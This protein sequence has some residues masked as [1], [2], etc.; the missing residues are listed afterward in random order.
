[1]SILKLFEAFQPFL[2][3]IA[4][5]A[6]S[7]YL[8]PKITKRWQDQQK[9]IELKTNFISEISESVLKMILAV[10]FAEVHS[11][12]QT[13][14]QYSAAYREWE[15]EKAI[16]G[17]K[18]R[19]YFPNT[20]L[21]QDWDEYADIVTE[22]YALSGTTDTAFRNDRL[23]G[24]N[25]YFDNAAIDWESL[26]KHHLKEGGFNKFQIYSKAWFSLR[27]STLD[28]KDALVQ[29]ILNS[30]VALFNY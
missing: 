1:M 12:S 5:G 27:K 8:I 7:H 28:R 26:E 18:I 3:L 20:T 16:I 17:S 4:T 23:K 29:E 25:L 9:E 11:K 10:Q 21:G 22:V 2:L 30:R 14:E 19:G 15:I 24:L 6:I 13:Q